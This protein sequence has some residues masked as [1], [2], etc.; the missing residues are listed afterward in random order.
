MKRCLVWLRRGN[1][2]PGLTCRTFR[3]IM[4]ISLILF[5]VI[6]YWLQEPQTTRKSR[7]AICPAYLPGERGVNKQG[8]YNMSPKQIRHL[9]SKC[10][11]S[12]WI[13]HTSSFSRI[14]NLRVSGVVSAHDAMFLS[15]ELNSFSCLLPLLTRELLHR[16]VKAVLHRAESHTERCFWQ[17][18][19][20]V[21]CETSVEEEC[22][23]TVSE[24]RPPAET[25]NLSSPVSSHHAWHTRVC[26]CAC[27]EKHFIFPITFHPTL[28]KHS[29]SY[30]H[31]ISE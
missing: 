9:G 8:N 18:K 13:F 28:M 1:S 7:A 26:V 11:S 2:L 31:N 30:I 17:N 12:L 3:T 23:L 19:K 4:E 14:V 24:P 6:C 20:L 15:F 22:V 25:P 29:H 10:C 5:A 16:R 27:E 21:S